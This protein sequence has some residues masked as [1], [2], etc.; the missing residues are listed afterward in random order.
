MKPLLNSCALAAL[1]MSLAGHAGAI[2]V[3]TAPIHVV[4][5]DVVE[6]DAQPVLTDQPDVGTL[7]AQWARM[8]QIAADKGADDKSADARSAEDKNAEVKSADVKG[9][10][11]RDASGA[12]DAE[13]PILIALRRPAPQDEKSAAELSPDESAFFAALGHRITD[14]ASA[15]ERYVRGASAIEAKFADAESIQTALNTGEAYHPRQLQEGQIAY[16]AVLALRDEAFVQGV[17]HWTGD[18][19][20]LIADPNLAL[21]I[22]GADEAAMDVAGALRAQAKALLASGGAL[23]RAAYEVQ[24]QSWSRGAVDQPDKVLAGAKATAARFST[25]DVDGEH[26][27][28][29]SLVSAP[30]SSA[31]GATVSPAVVQGL[32]LAALAIMGQAGDA[33]EQAFEPL[34]HDVR[35]A[36]CLRM[37]KMNLNQ[38]LAVAGPQYED[39]FCLGKHAV[40]ETA[41]C[42]ISA[43]EVA[44]PRRSAPPMLQSAALGEEPG[45]ERAAAYGLPAPQAASEDERDL[46]PSRY[47]DNRDDTPPPPPPA[48][49]RSYAQP[50]HTA[51][52]A[53]AEQTYPDRTYAQRT[54]PQRTYP[55][56]AYAY[57][58]YAYAAYGPYGYA[59]Y[60]YGPLAQPRRA[61]GQQAYNDQDDR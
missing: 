56:Q 9:A 4:P 61:Y 24:H 26:R 6:A 37:A 55:P 34:L 20:R 5:T 32:A 40:G 21:R 49:G 58:P 36:D 8:R 3:K 47:A 19:A 13:H 1:M 27:L 18:G 43:V 48:Y 7:D 60:G 25:A 2:E 41:Q 22:S 59:P 38:C 45:P 23:D 17:R 16:A 44:G 33:S 57:A 52:Q 35:N 15:Y 42:L 54:Y 46:A 51:P 10:D 30:Q 31:D 28:L 11:N 53:Y 50:Q 39:V 29:Q 14:A 12:G